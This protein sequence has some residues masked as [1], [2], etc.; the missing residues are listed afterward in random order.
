MQIA[1]D[2][3]VLVYAEGMNGSAKQTQILHILQPLPAASVVIPIQALGELFY[4]LV[5][6]ARQPKSKARNRVLA[7]IDTFATIETSSEVLLAAADLAADHNLQ[8]W[9]AV[10]LSAAA[11]AGCRFLL[12]EDLQDDFTWNGVTICNPFSATL[13]PLL[14]TL[15]SEAPGG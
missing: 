15:L 9:D 7:W 10:I 2:T 13:H 12:S 14:Q 6:K 1:L 4:V 11:E 3:N 5:K 8:I